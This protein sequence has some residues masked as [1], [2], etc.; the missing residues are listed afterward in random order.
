VA[1]S[2]GW[3]PEPGPLGYAEQA[4]AAAAVAVAGVAVVALKSEALDNLGETV[5]AEE[6][7][8]FA[9]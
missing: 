6:W 8:V 1:P 5:G 4:A 9:P 3:P 2:T 7:S